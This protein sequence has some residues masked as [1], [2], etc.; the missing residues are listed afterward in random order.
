MLIFQSAFVCQ[1]QRCSNGLRQVYLCP[2]SPK[3][4]LNQP[5]AP[6]TTTP[7]APF[8]SRSPHRPTIASAA[9]RVCPTTRLAKA[10]SPKNCHRPRTAK[11]CPLHAGLGEAHSLNKHTSAGWPTHHG[12]LRPPAPK[13]ASL[14]AILQHTSGKTNYLRQ[15]VPRKHFEQ[16]RGAR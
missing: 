7:Q 8:P 6:L 13:P 12:A 16:K 4:H 10:P 15:P 9:R 11:P 14:S 1:S 5:S 3:A 2:G